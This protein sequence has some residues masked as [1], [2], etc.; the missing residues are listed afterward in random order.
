[1]IRFACFFVARV[2]KTQAN[3]KAK[4][5]AIP[6]FHRPVVRDWPPSA[7]QAQGT[8]IGIGSAWLGH[9]FAALSQFI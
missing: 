1:V 6:V 2:A 8:A 4:G 3:K 5:A 7:A 9:M